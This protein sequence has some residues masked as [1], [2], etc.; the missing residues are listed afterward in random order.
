MTPPR[1]AARTV[2][3]DAGTAVAV[4]RAV[5]TRVADQSVVAEAV[6]AE[7]AAST[8]PA[9][10]RWRPYTI[11]SGWAGTALLLGAMDACWPGEGWDL[12]GH[13]HLAAACAALE[14]LPEVNASLFGGLAGI[15]YAAVTLDGDRHRYRRLLSTVDG[16]LLPK[17]DRAVRQLDRLHGCGVGEFDLISGLAGTG[18][19][20]L[21]RRSESAAADE[22][23]GRLLGCLT[24]LLADRTEPRR[25][26][27]PA[28]LVTGQ[29]RPAYPDG[30]YNCGIAHGVPGPLALLAIAARAGLAVDGMAAA[31][32]AAAGWLAD[33]AMPTE[34]GPEW[35]NAVSLPPGDPTAGGAGGRTAWC[36]GAPGVAR[37]LWLAG[38]ATGEQRYRDLAVQAMHGVLAR[39]AARRGLDSPTFCHGIAGLLQVTCRFAA[40]T[41]SALFQ[42]GVDAVLADLLDVYEPGSVLGY[43]NTEP[44]SVRVDSPGLLSGAPGVALALLAAGTTVEPSWD[45][46]FLV[47]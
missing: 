34:F 16:A 31:I 11:A 41:G 29:M 18:V 15:G 23:L 25:W 46:L 39:P 45:R 33:H 36:Y 12:A 6:A 10:V 44:G 38:V 24:R 43:R 1:A 13:T 26:H 2:A 17:V 5:A 47:A 37:A 14:R 19:Y 9:S 32:A 35:P 4:A 40:D 28:R 22:V 21:A 20:L 3:S 42:S 8:F 27:T 30:N 7:Q